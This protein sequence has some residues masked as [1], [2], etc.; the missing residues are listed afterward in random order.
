MLVACD[1]LAAQRHILLEGRQ[2]PAALG[3]FVLLLFVKHGKSVEGDRIAGRL[4]DI[5]LA[6]IS[7][8]VVLWR[9]FAIWQA[10]KRS[11]ISL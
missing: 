10:M 3:V 6:E 5:I 2:R 9:Q 11:Q 7:A 4:E 1:L 8:C